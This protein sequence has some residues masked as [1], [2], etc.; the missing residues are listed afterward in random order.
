MNHTVVK[1]RIPSPQT[2]VKLDTIITAAGE[3]F[4]WNSTFN[5]YNSTKDYRVL[6]WRDILS[7]Q[8]EEKQGEQ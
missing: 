4:N 5:C 6:L 2:G 1:E 3:R 7:I 8:T